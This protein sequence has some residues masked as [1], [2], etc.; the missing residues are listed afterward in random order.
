MTNIRA[1]CPG[2]GEV[3]LTADDIELQISHDEDESVYSFSCPK[4]VTDVSKPA[5]ARI[6]QLLLSGG[7]KAKIVEPAMHVSGDPIFTYDDLLDFH[8]ELESDQA[9]QNF[10]QGA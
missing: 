5:D 4:C 1:T 3:D 8:L 7:V 9:L 6:I 10:L 2:C